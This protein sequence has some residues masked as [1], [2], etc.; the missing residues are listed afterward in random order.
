MK[1]KTISKEKKKTWKLF[2]EYIRKRDCLRT[3]GL[4][5][6]GNCFTCDKTVP[7][8]LLQAGHFIPGR[9]NAGLFSERG[10][11]AQ[12]YN[13]NVNLRGAT[14]EYRRRIVVLYGEGADEEIEAEARKTKKFTIQELEQLQAD[15]RERLRAMGG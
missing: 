6:Y 14:L 12:C 5:D 9:H 3:T 11:Q 4:I 8:K 15:L 13:C 10:V 1:T 2:S 7:W